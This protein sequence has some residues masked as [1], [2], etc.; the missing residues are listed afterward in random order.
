VLPIG[1]DGLG[2]ASGR[3][4]LDL[5]VFVVALRLENQV[6]RLRALE[7][8]DE[9][10]DVVV[11]LSVRQIGNRETD[12]RVLDESFDRRMLFDLVGGALLPD[13]RVGDDVVHVAL[14][15]FAEVLARP[16][17]DI[18]AGAG[19]AVGFLA[20]DFR[21]LAPALVGADPFDEALNDPAVIRR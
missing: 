19:S 18:G 14:Y 21:S 11:V 6:Q 20:R 9:I 2:P 7:T 13:L 17:I 15:R 16:G 10:G 1:V 4:R 3:L 8:N 12:A 5:R